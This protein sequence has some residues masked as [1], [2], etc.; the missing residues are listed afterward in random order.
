MQLHPNHDFWHHNFTLY[1]Y[2]SKPCHETYQTNS[3]FSKIRRLAITVFEQTLKALHA[4]ASN[5]QI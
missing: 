4:F 3:T 1:Y 5:K 2:S